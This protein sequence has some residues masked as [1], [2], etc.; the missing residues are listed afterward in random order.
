MQWSMMFYGMDHPKFKKSVIV[1]EYMEG[2]LKMINLKAF[3]NGLKA[4]WI[5]RLVLKEN[6]WSKFITLFIL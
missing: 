2:G 1:K 4:T 3:I 5:R 6:K